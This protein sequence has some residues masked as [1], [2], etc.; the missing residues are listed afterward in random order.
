MEGEPKIRKASDL[1]LTDI[2]KEMQRLEHKLNELKGKITT[3]K[4]N[5]TEARE[6]YDALVTRRQ[7]IQAFIDTLTEPE[8]EE[9]KTRARE[10]LEQ[11][12]AEITEADELFRQSS[13]FNSL[14]ELQD[15]EITDSLVELERRRRREAH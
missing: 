2:E 7:Q 5:L 11:V 1:P 13:A 15:E 10:A 4:L 6:A 9:M 12:N 14:D 3:N 8:S